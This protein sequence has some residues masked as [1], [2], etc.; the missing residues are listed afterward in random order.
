MKNISRRGFLRGSLAG[1]GAAVVSTGLT[2]CNISIDTDDT[3]S[4]D[5]SRVEFNYGV[6]AGDPQQDAVIIWT[7]VTPLDQQSSVQVG[8]QVAMDV[9]FTDIIHNGTT[10]TSSAADFTVKVDLQGLDSGTTYYYRF[11]VG[12]THSVVGRCRTLPSG[13]P[14]QVKLA[15]FSCANY[16][17]GY[18]NAYTD[19]ALQN[20]LDAVVHLGDYIY[21]YAMGGYATDR[22]VEIGRALPANNDV[23]CISLTDYR[24]RYAL[25]RT[26]QGLAE[27]HRQHAFISVWDDHEITNDT[28]QDGAENHNEGEGDFTER[29]MAALRAY[30][31]WMPIRPMVAGDYERIYRNFQ[32]GDLVNLNMLDT[33]VLARDLQ[34]NYA[35]YI[36]PADG[37]LDSAA[38]IADVSATDRELLGAEQLGWLQANLMT[39]TA[40]WQVLG[41]QVLMGRMNLPAEMLFEL[42]SPSENAINLIG[43]LATIKARILQGDPTVTDEER[44]R[45]ETVIPYNLDAWDGYAYEREVIFATTGQLNHN[46]VVLAGD[47]HN[48]WATKL[49]NLDGSGAGVEFA[50]AGVS[51]P[52]MEDYLGLSE[53][54]IPSAEQAIGL[55]VDDLQYTNLSNRGYMLVS[56]TQ[57]Q[58]MA[59][60]VFVDNIEST[61]YNRLESRGVKL[62]VN[63]GTTD[64]TPVA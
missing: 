6:A 48:A 34:L 13:S 25:Y 42:A 36:N 1:F 58:A 46:L 30:F 2:G 31:E 12:N 55:L 14:E 18:F 4:D 38:F 62:A 8:W 9:N 39:N 16:P 47:T 5:D 57:A 22:A 40:R 20:D 32:F 26:D 10:T 51:S 11:G 19:A 59:E 37:S 63:A 61:D 3:L 54:A 33:R 53:A 60:W 43:E 52:G 27:L 45:V 28:W 21:E 44:A 41:Q 56:F 15:V 24:L 23:E 50:T 17:A 7:H 35:N 49:T 29:K 64:L